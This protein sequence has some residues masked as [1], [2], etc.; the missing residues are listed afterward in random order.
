[1]STRERL[2]YEQARQ[3]AAT[4][5][6]WLNTGS[7]EAAREGHVAGLLEREGRQRAEQTAEIRRAAERMERR[8]EAEDERRRKAERAAEV[9]ADRARREAERRAGKQ[10]ELEEL[11]YDTL[12]LG[13]R[14]AAGTA[15]RIEQDAYWFARR[16][17]ERVMSATPDRSLAYGLNLVRERTPQIDPSPRSEPAAP[18][19]LRR[20]A[21]ELLG[22]RR[23]FL[24][25]GHVLPFVVG[26]MGD[27]REPAGAPPLMVRLEYAG[28]ECLPPAPPAWLQQEAPVVRVVP[29]E[30][31]V[32][33]WEEPLW[34][35]ELDADVDELASRQARAGHGHLVAPLQAVQDALREALD[36][37]LWKAGARWC[38]W[39]RWPAD[40]PVSPAFDA[41]FASVAEVLDFL[42]AHRDLLRRL[43]LDAPGD[44]LEAAIA[45]TASALAAYGALRVEAARLHGWA[46]SDSLL[47]PPGPLPEVGGSGCIFQCLG[48][49]QEAVWGAQAG[50]RV[51]GAR[52][53]RA[54]SAIPEGQRSGLE[55]AG[56]GR[57]RQVLQ[58]FAA[59][60]GVDP[61]GQAAVPP[62]GLV[63]AVSWKTARIAAG[64]GEGA[65]APGAAPA[66]LAGA[67]CFVLAGGAAASAIGDLAFGLV[68]GTPAG[69]AVGGF[70]LLRLR[71]EAP[72]VHWLRGL[73]AR[74]RAWS[75]ADFA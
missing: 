18:A 28:Q 70:C 38:G 61:A 67:M 21:V 51:F 49:L 55:G 20:L 64:F 24:E 74:A 40:G 7:S 53:A 4:G 58:A 47:P 10:R 23:S 37:G 65:K 27:V 48:A 13:E 69:L 26:D 42:G 25:A 11:H 43:E 52:A 1:M 34:T 50:V 15:T 5:W 54:W 16:E 2:D 56:R 30:L 6:G 73:V 33:D 75:S 71:A 63:D 17:L 12:M 60:L 41:A 31:E 57:L 32:S 35:I 46:L 39:T 44:V 9:A 59:G 36:D 14:V 8:W 22:L 66:V 19:S 29:V 62:Q 3:R 68:V 45:P 72:S